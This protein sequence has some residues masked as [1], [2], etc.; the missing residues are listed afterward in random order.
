MAIEIY[1]YA[2]HRLTLSTHYGHPNR[3]GNEHME[4][5]SE[6]FRLKLNK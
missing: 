1:M 3:N 4:I 6:I 5:Y 2:N